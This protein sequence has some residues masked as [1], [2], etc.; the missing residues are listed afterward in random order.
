MA[1]NKRLTWGYFTLLIPIITP[2]YNW[3]SGAHLSYMEKKNHKKIQR[4][5]LFSKRVKEWILMDF[6][7]KMVW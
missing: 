2:M 3:F 5:F 7:D 1:E 6:G 4:D